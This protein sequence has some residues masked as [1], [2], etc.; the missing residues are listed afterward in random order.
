MLLILNQSRCFE[1]CQP[2]KMNTKMTIKH[3]FC[4][5]CW[6]EPQRWLSVERNVIIIHYSLNWLKVGKECLLQ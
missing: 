5:L 1:Q 4:V 6:L 2:H 3:N